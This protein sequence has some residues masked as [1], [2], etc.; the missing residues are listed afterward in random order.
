[1]GWYDCHFHRF[2]IDGVNYGVPHSDDLIKIKNEKKA[3]LN[4]VASCEMSTFLYEYDFGDCWLHEIL[5]EKILPSDPDTKYPVCLK[6]KRA[7][8]PEDIGGVPGY[9]ML[10][11]G[12]KNPEK[13]E[14]KYFLN[15][16]SGIF[17]QEEFDLEET[18]QKLSEIN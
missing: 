6:G 14:Y 17:D 3:K 15:H 8:P 4:K 7:C 16:I 9:T 13:P 12:L 18:H 2:A 11:L 5:A 1:M 10:Q